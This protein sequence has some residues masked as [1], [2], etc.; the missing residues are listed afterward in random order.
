MCLHALEFYAR[1]VI[2]AG[3]VLHRDREDLPGLAGAGERG[4]G[5]DDL[6]A[7]LAADEAEPHV[8][9]E[10]TREQPGLAE[11]LEAVADAEHHATV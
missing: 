2:A 9:Q 7:H 3:R 1:R 5:V 4:L 8:R 11:D 6:D 10:R